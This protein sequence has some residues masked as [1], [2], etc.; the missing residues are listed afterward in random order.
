ML[1]TVLPAF[2]ACGSSKL[3]STD[4]GRDTKTDAVA[5]DTAAGDGGSCPAAS[6]G[7]LSTASAGRPFGWLFTAAGSDAGTITDAGVGGRTDAATATDGAVDGGA[8]PARCQVVPSTGF[9]GVS[10]LGTASLQSGSSGPRVVFEDGAS[11]TWNGSL[12]AL[13]MPFVRQ[14]AG[15]QVWVDFEQR[16][17]VVCPVCGAYTTNTLELRDSAGGAVRFYD[18]AGDVLPALTGAQVVE[19]FGVT[20]IAVQNC[21]FHTAAT[22]GCASFVRTEFDHRLATTPASTIPDATWTEVGSPNG[23]YQVFWASSSE[24]EVHYDTNC[25]DGAGIATD[26]GFVAALVAP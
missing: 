16:T 22:Y 18:Q 4:A 1:L 25:L 17:T 3:V 11:L 8:G 7:P 21:S 2:V 26:N 6:I 24:T 20:A 23:K 12:P 5:V 15:D 14:A 19:I 10:C 13:S 9:P